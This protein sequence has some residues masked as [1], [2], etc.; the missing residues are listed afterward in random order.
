MPTV[1]PTVVVVGAGFAGLRAARVLRRSRV[2]I[3]VVDRKNHHLFQPLLYQVATAALSPADI[4]VPIRKVLRDQEN[5]HVLLAEVTSV[6]LAARTVRVD[7]RE[8]AYDWLV[9]APG[10]THSWFG[11]AEWA[12]YAPGLKT[13][14]DA[15]EIRRRFL[16][17]FEL[18]EATAD[19]AERR[20][21]LTFAVVGAGPTGVE[22]AGAMVEIARRV[23]PEDFRAIDAASAR[24][25]LLEA[26][27]RVL[28]A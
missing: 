17:A 21:A 12:P 18:A 2:R 27:P 20:A 26:G 3:V 11:H 13:I 5:A 19:P 1:S 15:T 10:V 16:L 25:L 28:S 4:A 8:L 23:L 6:D 22:L 14:E 24:I 7:G 9:L